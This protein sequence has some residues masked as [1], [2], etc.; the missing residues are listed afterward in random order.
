MVP[1][2]VKPKGGGIL[3]KVGRSFAR[4]IGIG[5]E[6]FASPNDLREFALQTAGDLRQAGLA[7]AGDLLEAAATYVTGSGWEWL[8]ELMVAARKIRRRFTLSDALAAK[9]AR[10]QRAA[11]SGRPYG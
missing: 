4:W 3:S 7:E 8:G 1:E 10:I 9:V 2:N 5:F 6:R 11:A